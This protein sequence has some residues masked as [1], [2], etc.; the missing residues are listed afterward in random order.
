MSAMEQ[1]MEKTQL[2][3]RKFLQVAGALSATATLY[4]CSGGGDGSQGVVTAQDNLVLDKT[5]QVVMSSHPFNC[6]SRCSF[7]FY[8][9]ADNFLNT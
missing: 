9:R 4:G 3:R 5:M 6:G 2:S 1:L 7:K 8:V